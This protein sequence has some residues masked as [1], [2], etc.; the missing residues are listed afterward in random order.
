MTRETDP[1]EV[2][3]K[4]DVRVPM[5]DGVT[6]AGNLYLPDADGPFPAIL[7][8]I[9][10]LKD[11]FGGL[12]G[13]DGYQRQFASR[14][15]AV[16]QLDFRGVGSSDGTNPY[17]FDP[18]ERI[19]AHEAVEWIANQPWC[20]GP[21]GMWGVSYGGITAIATATTHPPNLKAIIPVHATD[22]NWNSLFEHRGSRLML[23]ADPH[24]G[25]MMTANNLLPPLR[26]DGTPDWIERWYER[27][28][29]NTPWHLTWHGEH[30]T[31][32]YW[33]KQKADPTL[34]EIP[35]FAI[36]G[37]QDA[38]PEDMFRIYEAVKAPKRVLFGPWKHTYPD[39][40]PVEPIDY[41][42]EMDK[43]WD[44]WLKEVPND[45]EFDPPV[46]L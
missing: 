16:M 41:V 25:P 11:G 45:V 44:R 31:S 13:M 26:S 30:P 37:W 3:V 40:A 34:V 35:M 8:Y 32:E 27:L 15:Y 1:L 7:T 24:W 38:Y 10:Y 39:Q 2:K 20:S 21:V 28:E 43:W 17:P 14:G 23:L 4:Y 18:R 29:G 6:L 12:G 9:P 22:D 33:E 5:S 19:D 46:T 42:R 36:C